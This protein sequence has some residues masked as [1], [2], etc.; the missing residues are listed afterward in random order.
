VT[1]TFFRDALAHTVTAGDGTPIVWH[2]HPP[3]RGAP[4]ILTNGL[5]T[6]DEF[7]RHVVHA[8]APHHRVV[9]WSYRGHGESGSA[10][11]GDYSIA[12]HADDLVRVA[13]DAVQGPAVHIAFSM[14]VTVTLEAYRRRPDLMRALVLI[15]GGADGPYASAL[16]MRG[17]RARAAMRAAVRAAGNLAV[18]LAP[19]IRSAT[20]S[21]ALLPLAQA[22]GAV[23]K[24]A[25]RD[26]MERFFR[27]VGEMDMRAYWGTLASLMEA[28]ASDL[29]PTVRV[30]TLVIAPERDVMA[31]RA[32]L[33][34]L[35]A[36]IPGAQW[37]LFEGT[38]HALLVEQ[39]PRVAERIVR[40]L[41][42]L[43][44]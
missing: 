28:H 38:G 20:A 9:H 26:V 12:T 32:D 31:L 15:A 3:G 37:E 24:D 27:G 30:P 4:V 21:R 43:G 10:A 29:L 41:S 2:A 34:A 23:G 42:G 1:R 5:S 22:V 19:V 40:F 44:G 11:S 33:A 18:P 14:G 13:Q 7:W 36:G 8:L 16:A 25:P 39:G 35:H 17:P 6:T